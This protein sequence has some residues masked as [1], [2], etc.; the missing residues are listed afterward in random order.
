MK[1]R[2]PSGACLL[3]ASFLLQ[4]APVVELGT[5]TERINLRPYVSVLED[6]D[7]VLGLPDILQRDRDFTAVPERM[8]DINFGYSNS[9]YWLKVIL[10]TPEVADRWLLEISFPTL[11]S[12]TLYAPDQRGE[13]MV[14]SAGDR[15]PFAMRPIRHR[16]FVFPL[17]PPQGE[18]VPVYLRIRSEG[19]LTVP[20]TLWSN[21]A[22]HERSQDAYAGFSVYYGMLLALGVYNLLLFVSLRDRTFLAYVG[23]VIGM[24]IGQLSLNGLGNQYLWPDWPAWGNAAFNSGFA[25]SGFFAGIFTRL[26]LDT[27]QHIPR[28]DRLILLLTAGFAIA[29][30]APG[31]MPYQWA[32]IMTSLLAAVFSM[33]AVTAGVISL[34]RGHTGARWFLLAWTLLLLGVGVMGLRNMGWIPTTFLTTYGMQIGSALEI[35]LLSF[36][37]ADRFHIAQREKEQAQ[38]EALSAKEMVLT[39]LRESE[40]QLEERV[41]ERTR[42]LAEANRRLVENEQHLLH[43]ANHDQLTGLANR[44]LLDEY[45]NHALAL[46]KRHGLKV[47]V[48]LIDLDEF[49]EVNDVHGHAIGDELLITLADRLRGKIRESDIVARLGG[50]EFVV[51]FEQIGDEDEVKQKTAVLAAAL[52]EPYRTS[53]GLLQVGASI[54][55]A[56]FP[57][58]GDTPQALLR[59]ADQSMYLAKHNR[60]SGDNPS[61]G[62]D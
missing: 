34:R 60:A 36:A 23:I 58:D 13:W 29:T 55:I 8:R 22:F 25:A 18:T 39:G 59:Y 33:T 4:A 45:F 48:L 6:P 49:K 50:D 53:A 12:V 43:L 14:F 61:D 15:Q 54:G 9:T 21:Q 57:E 17:E 40:R 11:D 31:F 47:A 41:A 1:F 26:F 62:R 46:A 3:L 20:L 37:L 28:L 52:N 51:V 10:K 30:L 56:F 27:R 35:L 19:S 38:A 5:D 7:N 16:N 44:R 2:L 24:A 32:A 42:E